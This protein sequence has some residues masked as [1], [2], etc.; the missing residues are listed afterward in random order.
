MHIELSI[1]EEAL[2]ALLVR[3]RWYTVRGKAIPTI[4][5]VSFNYLA[6]VCG[7]PDSHPWKRIEV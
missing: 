4:T 3:V 6:D 5:A 7:K 2:D 1:L